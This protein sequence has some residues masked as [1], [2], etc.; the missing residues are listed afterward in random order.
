MV[1][2]LHSALQVSYA[3]LTFVSLVFRQYFNQYDD[4]SKTTGISN[5]DITKQL[6]VCRNIAFNEWKPYTE[7]ATTSSTIQHTIQP[8]AS[9][10]QV[11][12]IWF[13]P[14][15]LGK[16][17]WSE[18]SEIPKQQVSTKFQD[19]LCTRYLKISLGLLHIK[20]NSNIFFQQLPSINDMT[21]VKKC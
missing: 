5:R 11:E 19:Y 9:L 12:S 6:D 17:L 7:T 13:V 15:Q 10:F 16:R 2:L 3:Y 20:G 18:R 8:P 1:K 4:Q 21:G 14:N